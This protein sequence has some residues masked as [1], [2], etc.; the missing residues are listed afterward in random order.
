MLMNDW[1]I[2]KSNI[3]GQ[4]VFARRNFV[5]N[6]PISIIF[7][8]VHNC[9]IPE[10]DLVRTEFCRYINHH[11]EGNCGIYKK[12]HFYILKALKDIFSD[13]EITTN[14]NEGLAKEISGGFPDELNGN[15]DSLK[16]IP[17]SSQIRDLNRDIL[18][19]ETL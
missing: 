17:H 10:R 15:K 7:I 3:H 1:Y 12:N 8:K 14:Y 2:D 19:I 13:D 11:N 18:D 9:G 16:F 6:E 5:K 4:G